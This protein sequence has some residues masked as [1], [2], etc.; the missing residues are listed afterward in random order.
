MKSTIC[1]ASK[2]KSR[3][4]V[5]N[6]AF[7]QFESLPSSIDEIYEGETV[8]EYVMKL[9]RMKCEDVIDK[10][11]AEIVLGAD[12]VAIL[13][14]EIIEKPKDEVDAIKILQKLQ[15]KTH[16]FCTGLYVARTNPKKVL[17]RF[18]TTKVTFSS[19]SN[20]LIKDYVERFQPFTFAGGYD[21]SISS[22]FIMGID[23]SIS[24]LMG[25]PMTDLREMVEELGY[26]WFQFIKTSQT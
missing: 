16:I 19:M 26:S 10:T 17:S 12:S 7:V 6:R 5:L 22:W 25:L 14:E 11:N 20:D 9:A 3:K 21:N 4:D 1:L 15:G 13:G 24:N 18:I 23:G 2:S 8:D